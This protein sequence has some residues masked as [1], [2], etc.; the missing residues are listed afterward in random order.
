MD[1]KLAVKSIIEEYYAKGEFSGSVLVA[2]N[3][4]IIFVGGCGKASMVWNIPAT[5][6]T[7]YLVASL[8]K[9][10][11]AMLVMQ[12]VQE[13]KLELDSPISKYLCYYRKDIGDKVTARHLL[14]HRSG[15]PN[16]SRIPEFGEDIRKTFVVKEF[17]EKYC[18]RDLEFEPDSSFAYANTGYYI[19]GAIIEEM[20]G[21]AYAEALGRYI[22]EPAGMHDSGCPGN[23]E[24]VEQLAEGYLKTE[25]GYRRASYTDMSTLFAAGGLYSTVEDLY[26]WDQILYTDKL[27]QH[28]YREMMFTGHHNNYGFGWGGAHVPASDIEKW[29]SNR[30]TYQSHPNTDA[31]THHIVSHSGDVSGYRSQIMRVLDQHHLIVILSNVIQ[32]KVN[33]MGL[34]ILSAL[35]NKQRS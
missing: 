30:L 17:I 3:S 26:K 11:T 10:F 16:Y 8:S 24:V 2:E 19:L 29:N 4:R 34:E 20:R 14:T 13:G 27:L 5:N 35:L 7:R 23:T 21:M 15:I 25:R 12:L 18:C 33:E 31:V 9:Q 1:D 22:L 32:S 28:Q 6:R